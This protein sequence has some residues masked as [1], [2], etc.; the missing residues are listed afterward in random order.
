[1][2]WGEV[3][4]INSN[5]ETPLNSL[6]SETSAELSTIL[7]P[8]VMQTK[9]YNKN[10]QANETSTV[11]TGP[12]ILNRLWIRNTPTA[13]DITIKF[14]GESQVLLSNLTNGIVC[15]G[16]RYDYR[17]VIMGNDYSTGNPNLNYAFTEGL[18]L[19]GSTNLS[20][21]TSIYMD[22]TTYV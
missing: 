18:E 10:V 8:K 9:F 17:F 11:I 15:I 4:K 1:M 13:G 14:I 7:R 22:I 5:L 19:I 6:I 16:N 21:Q 20:I 3:L 2:S 12:G